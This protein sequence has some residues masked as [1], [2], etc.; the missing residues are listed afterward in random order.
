[1]TIY[2]LTL[3]LAPV[4]ATQTTN[5]TYFGVDE[6]TNLDFATVPAG[7]TDL[8]IGGLHWALVGVAWR[9]RKGVLQK[10]AQDKSRPGE[11]GKAYYTAPYLK[12]DASEIIQN[13]P[14]KTATLQLLVS[15]GLSN[16]Q[17]ESTTITI[18]R[19]AGVMTVMPGSEE[20]VAGVPNAGFMGEISLAPDDVSFSN[21][22][23]RE[24]SGSLT[25]SGCFKG[26]NDRA[27]WGPDG[28][29]SHTPT[30]IGG[31]GLP[32]SRENNKNGGVQDH[33]NTPYNPGQG[34][35][36]YPTWD[37][38]YHW[39]I[40]WQYRV[41]KEFRGSEN[42]SWIRFQVADHLS[43][44]DAAGRC[45]TSKAGAQVAFART[46]ATAPAAAPVP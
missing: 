14:T 5:H 31:N 38:R 2:Q 27:A 36:T 40:Y 9:N 46:D 3:R 1:V 44:S 6:R 23:F 22:E 7:V 18:H 26:W 21:L 35:N 15:G 37:G 41:R 39:K 8:Q 20:H 28:Q 4:V 13:T 43:V 32:I 33:V 16:G 29:K 25:A 34:A 30:I 19:P 45:V 11:N 12:D 42:G 17:M 24:A 10:R